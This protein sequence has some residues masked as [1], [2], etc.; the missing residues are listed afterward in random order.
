MSHPNFD[1]Q[2]IFF[3]FSPLIPYIQER[4]QCQNITKGRQLVNLGVSIWELIILLF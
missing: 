1:N 4:T 3:A 2:T